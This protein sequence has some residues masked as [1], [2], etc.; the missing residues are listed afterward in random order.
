M[1]NSTLQPVAD[2]AAGDRGQPAPEGVQRA[3]SSREPAGDE[4]E[5][6]PDWYP[7]EAEFQQEQV[8]QFVSE[9][10]DVDWAAFNAAVKA[11]IAKWSEHESIQ[12]VFVLMRRCLVVHIE[13]LHIIA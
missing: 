6:L 13:C 12:Y 7:L 11:K 3:E 8:K 2:T 10:G 9:S 5:R 1:A 4:D